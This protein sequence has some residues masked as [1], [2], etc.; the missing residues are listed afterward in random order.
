MSHVDWQLIAALL[1]VAAAAG[2]LIRRGLK[3]L[4]AGR[5]SEAACGTCGSCPAAQNAHVPSPAAFVPLGSLAPPDEEG[6]DILSRS[7]RTL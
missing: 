6:T 4:R 7:E 5:K 1:A 2:F 3:L